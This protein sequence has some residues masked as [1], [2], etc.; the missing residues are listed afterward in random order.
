MNGA[1]EEA[2]VQ[3]PYCWEHF[4]TLVDCSAGSQQYIEDCAVCCQPILLLAEVDPWG[5]LVS[6]E[7]RRGND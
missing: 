6:L 2:Q 4:T 1:L 3:C 5:A 7:A